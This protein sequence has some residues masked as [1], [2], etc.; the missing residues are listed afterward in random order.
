MKK[1]SAAERAGWRAR[2][3]GIYFTLTSRIT[4]LERPLHFTDEMVNGP[5]KRLHHQHIFEKTPDGTMM[6]DLFEFK[7]PFGK[8]GTLADKSFLENYLRKLLT[9]RN[10][11]IKNVAERRTE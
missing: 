10:E 3:F 11:L 4:E 7:S 8:L 6:T 5:F 1:R 9:K 2:H